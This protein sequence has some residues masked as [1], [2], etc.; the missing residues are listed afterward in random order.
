MHM[1]VRHPTPPNRRPRPRLPFALLCLLTFAFLAG[2]KTGP[3][4]LK[5]QAPIDRALVDYPPG[6]EL[7]PYVRGLTAPS[8]IAFDPADDSLLIA[9]SGVD[10][11]EPRIFGFKKDGAHFDVWPRGKRF[12]FFSKAFRIYAP[13]GGMVATGGKVYV[14]HRDENGR[15]RITAFSYDEKVPPRT[16]VADLPANGD[17]GI[18]D[19]A[20]NPTNGRLYFGVGAATNAAVV[21]LDN[22]QAGW[23]K[24]YPRFC[25]VPYVDVKLTGFRFDTKNPF[26]SI[27]GGNDIAVTG[28]F[29]PF[30]KSDQSSIPRP[31]PGRTTNEK[32]TAAVY[33]CDLAG[34]DLKVEAH[35]IRNPAGLRFTE[36]DTLY[37][38]NQGMELRGTRPIGGG[39]ESGPGGDPDAF[40]KMVGG[41]AWYGWPDFSTDLRPITEDTFQ[42][43]R[44]LA[45]RYGY[46]NVRFLID[47]AASRL[48]PPSPGPLLFGTFR[49][50]SGASKFDF[51]RGATAFR[52]Y[53]GD[54]VVALFGDRAPFAT[55]NRPMVSPT[56]YRVVTVNMDARRVEDFIRNTKDLPASRLGDDAR[57]ADALERPVDVKFDAA[58][59]LYVLDFGQMQMKNGRPD[60]KPGTGRIFRLS[61]VEAPAATATAP[62]A[63]P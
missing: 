15:G 8:A 29:Q 39:T 9:E 60:V 28:P 1:D 14:T 61:G 16:I 54:A 32:P 38:T 26:A 58:G 17:Y 11:N 20:Y 12:P 19:I 5:D 55:S 42:P 56:G 18:T 63:R 35:G 33:S 6:F 25:D 7:R 40:L 31:P 62:T 52:K 51:V 48:I 34:G 44:E 36:Y 45:I 47:H 41:E 24:K 46:P 23:T 4:V 49:P 53:R 57:N 50:L 13:V 3:E 43:P 37:M 22:L 21:G 30:G 27:F 2:C 10:N 59:A